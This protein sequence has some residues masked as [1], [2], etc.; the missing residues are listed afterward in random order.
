MLAD[1]EATA[2][3]DRLLD[4][5]RARRADLRAAMHQLEDALARPAPGRVRRWSEA[6]HDALVD[7]S[8]TFERHRA[9]TEGGDGLLAE[10]TE[11]SPRL[12]NAAQRLVDEHVRI[13]GL[14]SA[15]LDDLRH[16]PW[17]SDEATIASLRGQV[18]AVVAELT[19]HRQH[20][21]DL[22]W[23]AHAVDIGGSD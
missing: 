17:H 16:L 5:A 15:A 20:G 14:L 6:V 1:H 19:R 9:L 2:V 22:V 23:E 21:A 13:S 12:I 11:H 8:A 3:D 18:T 7:A 10:L 4:E